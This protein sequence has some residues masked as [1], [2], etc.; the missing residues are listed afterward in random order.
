VLGKR[1]IL[2]GLAV[3]IATAIAG[4]IVFS[5]KL[6]GEMV[7]AQLSLD[8]Y[9]SVFVSPV[10]SNEGRAYSISW[11]SCTLNPDFDHRYCIFAGGLLPKSAV[12]VQPNG[13]LTLDLDV[14]MMSSTFFLG[15]ENC[16]TGT[17]VPF[18]PPS[19]PLKGSF[20]VY[21]GAG[22]SFNESSGN[23]R[24]ET[25]PAPGFLFSQ[26]FSGHRT[27]YSANFTGLVGFMTVTPPPTG[28]NA[29]L[30]IMKGQQTFMTVYP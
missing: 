6:T 19:V 24:T 22:S 25:I 10:D 29:N 4:Q 23:N 30:T 20:T 3:V 1:A 11:R 21:R 27:Q 8:P 12:T 5:S 26:S 9:A 7:S 2:I 17:C 14:S 13:S 28:S 15:G 16:T 18:T